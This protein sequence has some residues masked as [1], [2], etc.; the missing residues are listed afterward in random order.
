MMVVGTLTLVVA[1]RDSIAAAGMTSAAVGIGAA[2]GGPLLGAA[3]DRWGQRPILL[4]TTAINGAA[5]LA[6]TAV[7]YSALAM[8][9]VLAA[10]ILTGGSAPQ[11]GPL[12]RSRLIA[13]ITDTMP[14]GGRVRSI[15][16][17]MSYESCVDEVTFVFGP[18]LIGLLA[19]TMG[20]AASMIGTAALTVVFVVTFALH[21]TATSAAARSEPG[22]AGPVRAL[23]GDAVVV[24]LAGAFGIG[25]VYGTVL[26]SLTAYL[27]DLGDGDAAGLVYGALG[28]GSAVFAL[29]SALLPARFS[30]RA[31]WVVSAV[32]IVAG[33]AVFAS[34]EGLVGVVVG[35]A[36]MGCGIGPAVVAV[37]SFGAERAP[38]GRYSTVMTMLGAAI[39]V[40]QALASA[41]AG[42]VAD[43]A[44]TATAMALPAG[45]AAL[46]VI[47][48]VANLG[49]RARPSA[50]VSH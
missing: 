22:A 29:S 30:Q 2:I 5:L 14:A 46:V 1:A 39:T 36:V 26:T 35:V 18:V 8:P 19:T 24:L 28:L 38:R 47:S 31:R 45:A 9:V 13:I 43:D 6:L 7:A 23:F 49:I 40:G 20:A 34:A 21:R 17:T 12:S 4:V 11:V 25:C 27:A 44:A 3:A 15:G 50:A 41:V 48:G 37:F 32:V 10:G 42:Q 33:A 16:R